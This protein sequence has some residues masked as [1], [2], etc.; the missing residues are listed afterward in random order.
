M[1]VVIVFMLAGTQQ[2]RSTSTN[3]PKTTIIS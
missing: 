2:I 3:L 1:Q